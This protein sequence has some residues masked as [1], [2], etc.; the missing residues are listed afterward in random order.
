MPPMESLT[1]K[2]GDEI[3]IETR[4]SATSKM[5]GIVKCWEGLEEAHEDYKM[6]KWPQ[7]MANV[8]EF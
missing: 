8:N 5:F 6:R 4:R 2:D 3:E 1:E 7:T